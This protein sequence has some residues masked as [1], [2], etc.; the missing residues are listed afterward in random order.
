LLVKDSLKRY[1]IAKYAT[2]FPELEAC[3]KELTPVDFIHS[4]EHEK[5]KT[6]LSIQK[7]ILTRNHPTVWKEIQ[8]QHLQILKLTRL[9][10]QAPEALEW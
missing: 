10:T 5:S 6:Y 4:L 7:D 9:F 8:R 3:M 2:S 1:T